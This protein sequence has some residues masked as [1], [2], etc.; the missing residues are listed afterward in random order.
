ML[1]AL[2]HYT[3]INVATAAFVDRFLSREMED[4]ILYL[5]EAKSS[6]STA[7]QL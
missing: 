2:Q 3:L 4:E 1:L 5:K 7:A 6:V